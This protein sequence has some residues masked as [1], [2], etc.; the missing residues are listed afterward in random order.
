MVEPHVAGCNAVSWG[1]A[2]EHCS[3]QTV[4]SEASVAPP[5]DPNK[6]LRYVSV[7]TTLTLH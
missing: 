3:A 7:S 2:V 1:G 4:Q 6:V 5:L